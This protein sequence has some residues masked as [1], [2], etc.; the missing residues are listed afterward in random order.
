AL[1]RA[2]ER[3]RRQPGVRW[4]CLAD[5]IEHV[6][7]NEAV[8]IDGTNEIHAAQERIAAS[9]RLRTLLERRGIACRTGQG[10]RLGR[11]EGR[12]ALL[13]IE[14]RPANDDDAGNDGP[15]GADEPRIANLLGDVREE[16]PEVDLLRRAA[17]AAAG[18][19]L[20]RS[21]EEIDLDH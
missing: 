13:L 3:E 6:R 2:H 19:F 16:R 12:D 4:E 18:L 8:L 14:I 21:G 9:I 7:P 5:L 17:A 1:R 15:D 20:A 10:H 11:A